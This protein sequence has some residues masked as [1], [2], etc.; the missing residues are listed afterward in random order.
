[1]IKDI[2]ARHGFLNSKI[3]DHHLLILRTFPQNEWIYPNNS[4]NEEHTICEWFA[5]RSNNEY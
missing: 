3:N 1:M 2:L 5:S 4:D